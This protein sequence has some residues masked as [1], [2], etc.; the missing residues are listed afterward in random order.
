MASILIVEDEPDV[1]ELVYE[2]LV[3][4]GYA[5]TMAL[6]DQAALDELARDGCNFSALVADINLG[7]GVTGFDIARKAR[8]LNRRIKVVYITGHGAHLSRFGVEGSVMVPK[9]FSASDLA[10]EVEALL[11][12]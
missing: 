1:A 8:Q 3:A 2:A 12:A 7:P 5:V 9:P 4:K 11:V 6:G 10:D